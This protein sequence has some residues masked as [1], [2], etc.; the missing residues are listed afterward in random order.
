MICGLIIAL[1]AIFTLP[2]R[3][4]FPVGV[5]VTLIAQLVP[6]ETV[7]PFK[8][9]VPLARAKFPLTLRV[10]RFRL[11]VPVFVRVTDFAAVVVPTFCVAKLTQIR[12]QTRLWIDDLFC[13][14]HSMRTSSCTV[15]DGEGCRC[16]CGR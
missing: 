2:R 13:H 14:R 11:V 15:V 9:V 4:P 8:Q 6:G 7:P 5:N 10:P 12:T 16:G 1:S 3:T